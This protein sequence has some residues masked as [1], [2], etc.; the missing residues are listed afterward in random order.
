MNKWTNER[1]SKSIFNNG[2]VG[3]RIERHRFAIE[4]QSPSPCRTYIVGTIAVNHQQRLDSILARNRTKETIFCVDSNGIGIF[5]YVVVVVV[6]VMVAMMMMMLVGVVVGRAANS[7]VMMRRNAASGHGQEKNNYE[8]RLVIDCHGR[9]YERD[10]VCLLGTM[11]KERCVG[12]PFPRNEFWKIA[13]FVVFQII[14]PFRNT[15]QKASLRLK[16]FWL[17]SNAWMRSC[18]NFFMLPR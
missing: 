8:W 3:A 6:M 13:S 1:N 9:S 12:L 15:I 5:V 7:P 17:T 11:E 14:S 2:A 10:W 18:E 16:V 4:R